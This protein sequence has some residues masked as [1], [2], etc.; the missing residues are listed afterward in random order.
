MWASKS[1]TK[2]F[3][4]LGITVLPL[5][6]V[7]FSGDFSF[8]ILLVIL[9][10]LSALL[11]VELNVTHC[12]FLGLMATLFFSV[13]LPLFGGSAIS[14]PAEPLV[15]LLG[16]A[17]LILAYRH[18][19]RFLEIW[20][21]PLALAIF[22]LVFAWALSAATSTMPLVS[23][24]YVFINLVYMVIGLVLFPMLLKLR[25][26]R[27]TNLFRWMLPALAFFALFAVFN[28]WPYRFSP[29]A[30][31]LIGL[32]FFKDHTVF[33]ATLSLFVPM[34][35]LWHSFNK[36]EGNRRWIPLAIGVLVL[37]A[38]FISSSRGA[39]LALILAAAFFGFVRLGG[40][41]VHLS[42]LLLIAAASVTYFFDDIERAFLVNPYNST[43]VASSLQDQ[44]LSVTN[45]NSD[46]SNRE[47]INR[48]KCAV[49]M[50]ADRPLVGFGPGT[51]QFQYFPYQRD[52]DRTYISV[53]SPFNTLVG[54]GGSAHSE[55]LLLLAESGFPGL[56]AWI[57]LQIALLISFFKIWEG[58]IEAQ[59]KQ[60]ALAV[61]LGILTF[62]IHS[63]FNNYLNTAQFGVSWWV[64]VGAMLYFR[65]K[66][67]AIENQA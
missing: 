67:K 5:L 15:L 12:V 37:F 10:C 31:S 6:V 56:L 11:L 20:R 23:M 60:L 38:L 46:V 52:L 41:L 62:T 8:T 17:A 65:S 47:R 1:I 44:A 59:D 13:E 26:F 28:L 22:V 64:F 54:R 18:K 29:E 25:Y 45:I 48:W 34:L 53:T 51:Y 9:G 33:S 24:K 49:R 40:R 21:Q 66:T 27:V 36:S 61:Y 55:Y 63:L 2:W 50:G 32:P 35:L 14:L 58:E 30:A 16:V 7:L 39:W 3:L 42:I 43:E 57:I 19:T 4:L